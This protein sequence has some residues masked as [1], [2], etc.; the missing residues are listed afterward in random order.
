MR[1]SPPYARWLSSESQSRPKLLRKAAMPSGRR[2]GP[3]KSRST[4]LERAAEPT[5]WSAVRTSWG[6]EVSSASGRPGA[7]TCAAG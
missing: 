2:I 1:V 7:C 3:E 6:D 4:R 5:T